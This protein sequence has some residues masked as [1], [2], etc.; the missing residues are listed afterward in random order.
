MP[1]ANPARFTLGLSRVQL[2]KLA[3]LHAWSQDLDEERQVLRFAEA[4]DDAPALRAYFEEQARE[5][6][7]QALRRFAEDHP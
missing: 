6:W 2:A 1:P 4:V 5:A 3:M 7:E